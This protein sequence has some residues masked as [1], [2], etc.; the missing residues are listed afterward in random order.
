MRDVMDLGMVSKDGYLMLREDLQELLA[1]KKYQE[2]QLLLEK[3]FEK[4]HLLQNQLQ[5]NE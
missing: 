1:K 4:K 3:A 2:Q 5:N